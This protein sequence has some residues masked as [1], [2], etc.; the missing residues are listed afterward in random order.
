MVEY[1][2]TKLQKHQLV[3]V[4]KLLIQEQVDTE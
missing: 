1:T 2:Q 4:V 3:Y